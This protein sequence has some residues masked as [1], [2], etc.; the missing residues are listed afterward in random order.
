M[1]V[2]KDYMSLNIKDKILVPLASVLLLVIAVC[3]IFGLLSLLF[4]LSTASADTVET[5]Q[6]TPFLIA[7]ASEDAAALGVDGTYWGATA[8]WPEIPKGAAN[9][10]IAFYAYDDANLT[11]DGNT[12]NAQVYIADFGGNAQLVCDV[13]CTIG[14]AQLSHNP[15]SP[16]TELNAGAADPCH[17]WVDT[18]DASPETWWKGGVTAQNYTGAD[19]MASLILNRQSGKRIWCRISEMSTTNLTVWCVGWFY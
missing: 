3:V 7:A 5:V 1:G 10:K 12:F 19:D 8:A 2:T 15:V 6:P 13:N 18:T 14:K 17:T 9:L 16:S 11:P 4:T